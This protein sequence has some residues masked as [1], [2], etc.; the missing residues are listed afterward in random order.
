[1]ISI[2]ELK[3]V[4]KDSAIRS[5]IDVSAALEKA[6]QVVEKYHEVDPDNTIE[7]KRPK[8]A[9]KNNSKGLYTHCGVSVHKGVLKLRFTN[10]LEGRLKT[11]QRDGDT[12]VRMITVDRPSTKQELAEIMIDDPSFQDEQ[13]QELIKT[14]LQ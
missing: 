5:R 9:R 8:A 7:N 3:T 2:Q 6:K 11:F 1:M 12:D 13:V 14:L 4:Q 10:D